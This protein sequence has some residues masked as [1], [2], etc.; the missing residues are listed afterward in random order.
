[1]LGEWSVTVSGVNSCGQPVPD[2]EMRLKFPNSQV[3]SQSDSGFGEENP[4]KSR[5]KP[6]PTVDNNSYLP[7][8]A[9]PA[10][11]KYTVITKKADGKAILIYI[12]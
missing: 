11:R 9:P 6:T 7:P 5:G 4:G 3:A 12:N 1:M 2:V 8:P 10:R